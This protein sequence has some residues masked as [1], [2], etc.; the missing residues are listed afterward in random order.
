MKSKNRKS[1]E[2]R[3][4]AAAEKALAVSN[5]VAPIDILLGIGWLDPNTARRWQQGQIERLE[6]VLQTSPA[7]IAEAM[8]LF[9]AW[10]TRKGLIP[11]ETQYLA[12]SPAQ[13]ALRFSRS[14]DTKTERFYR[15]H[16]TSPDLPEKKRKGLVEKASRAPELV[17]ILPLNK[18]W[19]CHKCGD[20][21][22]MLIMEK[23]GPSC[24]KC[25]GLDDLE[26]LDAG[27]ALLTR[28]AKA[29]SSRHAV[30]VRFSKTRRRYE[31]QGLLVAPQA[32][33]E[34]EAEVA[35]EKGDRPRK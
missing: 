19:K 12:R 35:R 1:L 26:F 23:P 22:D 21:G 3:V 8:R 9:E 29:K 28:R 20:Q 15:T 11:D 13:S 7:R 27:D 18:E 17:V 6:D 24:L 30:V 31:R 34:A 33:K 10:A 16:W 25:A 4:T 32:L 14:G 5:F 2:E